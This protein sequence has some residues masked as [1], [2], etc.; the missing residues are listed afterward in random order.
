MKRIFLATASLAAVT[1]LA[2]PAAA[3]GPRDGGRMKHHDMMK[4]HIAAMDTNGDGEISEAEV[5]AHREAMFA[6]IDTDGNG[7]LSQEE[8]VAHHEA[9]KAERRARMQAEMFSRFDKDGSGA[10]TKDEFEDRPMMMF[11]RFDDD[12]DGVIII[13]EIDDRPM[14][15]REV[16]RF[17]W[18]DGAPP[19][20][21]PPPSEDE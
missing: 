17:K 12:G 19:P 1:M 14:I 2:L 3:Q 6:A 13:D 18:K 15:R 5:E 8:L 11:E 4:E 16:R 9:K 21:P 10:V 20:P 7:T